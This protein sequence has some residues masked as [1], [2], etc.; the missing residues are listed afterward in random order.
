MRALD[1]LPLKKKVLYS[2]GEFGEFVPTYFISSYIF[3][4]YAPSNGHVILQSYIVGIVFFL[5]TLVQAIANPL[6]GSWSDKSRSSFGRRRFFMLSGFIPM[7]LSFYL[8]WVPTSSFLLNVAL[9]LTYML[10][11]NFLFAYVI[12]PYLA[13]IPEICTDSRDRVRLT[14]ISAY[15]SI[16]GIIIS[17]LVPA[18]LFALRLPMALVALVM[19]VIIILALLTVVLSIH[20][21][22]PPAKIPLRYTLFQGIK[23][24]F[25]NKTFNRYIIAYLSFQFGFAF[26]IS[27]LGYYVEDVIFTPA[28]TGYTS[29]IGVFTLVAV[30]SA[31]LF[32]PLLIR[33]SDRK[34][35]KNAFILFTFL[36][37]LP[38]FLTFVVGFYNGI[39]NVIQMLVLM[40]FAG[41]GLT[42][43]FILPNAILSEI[44]DED[45]IITGFRREG[46]YFG[47]QGF[48]E[49]FA[50]SFS[51]LVLGFW[52]SGLYDP[53]HNVIFVRFLGEYLP[54]LPLSF[55][56]SC[57]EGKGT[58]Q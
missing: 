33:Y 34:G 13:L 39:G 5:G 48:L 6:V 54:P 28:F 45:E 31:I 25:R 16:A 8:M 4:F 1:K 11:F 2:V 49:H 22:A 58:F 17:S 32:S 36:L 50:A 27:S 38:L 51:S 12:T 43:F 56:I 15:F 10:F 46:M 57:P 3:I 18:V 23:Q 26:F 42:S 52:M 9:L 24:T 55:S 41:V 37:S 7:T 20:E 44:I 30:L 14:T 47:V 29:Y 35:E 40:V 19:S 21:S 53:T